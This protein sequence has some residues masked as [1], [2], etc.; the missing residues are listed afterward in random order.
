[1]IATM[2]STR[3][4]M[5]TMHST[6]SGT[7]AAMEESSDNAMAMGKA[8]D[9]SNN[10]ESFYLPPDIFNNED[11]KRVL[12][13]FFSDDGKAARMLISQ[14]GDPAIARRRFAGRPDQGRRRGGTQG[15]AAGKQHDQ[16]RRQRGGGQRPWWSG[17]HLRP[18]DRRES[19]HSA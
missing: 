11:F 8:F 18:L 3:T 1:M 14:T 7:I 2:E 6:M 4:M 10:D 15:H 9:A 19:L 17:F 5:L 13:V 12:K 16:S